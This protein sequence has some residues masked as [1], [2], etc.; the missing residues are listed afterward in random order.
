MGVSPMLRL[1]GSLG[2]VETRSN[3]ERRLTMMKS[4]RIPS[5]L[6]RA[7]AVVVIL[8]LGALC[9]TSYAQSKPPI[10]ADKARMIGYVED[11]FMDNDNGLTARKPLAW[12][13]PT[14]DDK[15]NVTI[16]YKY[17]ASFRDGDR[18]V[19][20]DRFT[21]DKNGKFVEVKNLSKEPPKANAV[22]K[23]IMEV[24]KGEIET[25]FRE[26]KP[27]LAD[28]KA[29]RTSI[30][31]NDDG[32]YSAEYLFIAAIPDSTEGLKG[33][34]LLVTWRFTFDKSGKYVSHKDMGGTM[35]FLNEKPQ[36]DQAAPLVVRMLPANNAGDVDPN[37]P[38]L[39]LRFSQKMGT[40]RS[41]CQFSDDTF[42]KPD[43]EFT[44]E[45][46][47][48]G[49]TVALIAV[50]L[51]PNK[52]YTIG[53][54]TPPFKGFRSEAGELLPAYIYTFKTSDKSLDPSRRQALADEMKNT[55]MDSPTDPLLSVLLGLQRGGVAFSRIIETTPDHRKDVGERLKCPLAV[56]YN[57]FLAEGKGS[58][59]VNLLVPQNP[60]Q[61]EALKKTLA[62]YPH[63]EN[64]S[65]S[66]AENIIQLD[67]TTLLE[68]VYSRQL[69]TE[70][71]EVI[72]KA[73]RPAK[74]RADAP[75][76]V[77]RQLVE[78]WVEKF[79]SQN[80]RDITARQ[81][82]KFSNL[83]TNVDGTISIDYH[84]N[85][86]IWDKDGKIIEQ[87]FTFDRSG[88]YIGH[89]TLKSEPARLLSDD[90]KRRDDNVDDGVLLESMW[91]TLRGAGFAPVS[92]RAVKVPPFH[93]KFECPLALVVDV[94]LQEG[95]AQ[96]NIFVP[97][98][99]NQ[100]DALKKEVMALGT[101]EENVIQ[102]A[103][104]MLLQLI[105]NQ[106]TPE[107]ADTLR[108]SLRRP[109]PADTPRTPAR[110]GTPDA[111]PDE[112]T[113]S[114]IKLSHA[115]AKEMASL[116]LHHIR[117]GR[118]NV[119]VDTRTNS[120]LLTADAAD[121]ERVK[122]LI[123]KLDVPVDEKPAVK[124]TPASTEGKSLADLELAKAESETKI[125]MAE[126]TLE[127]KKRMY[128][129]AV[130][131]HQI[132]GTQDAVVE[133][134]TAE[135]DVTLAGQLLKLEQIVLE[136]I[137]AAI[138]AA[139]RPAATATDKPG[140]TTPMHTAAGGGHMDTM[141]Q[142]M[143]RGADVNAKDGN[144]RTPMHL[145][146][147]NDHRETVKWLKEQG[148]D[149]NAKDNAGQTPM[150][151]A[152]QKGRGDTVARLKELG[153]EVNAKDNDGRTPLHMAAQNGQGAT[154]KRLVDLGADIGV[155]D[156]RGKTALDVATQNNHPET[157]AWLA[158]ASKTDPDTSVK[159]AQ[160]GWKLYMQ[161]KA[162]DAEPL[163]EVATRL[164]PKNAN[165]WQGLGWSQWT[166]EK[167][168]AAKAS[169][170]IC[171][172]L[173]PKN[174][175]ALNGLGQ[176]AQAAGDLD[177]AIAHWKAGVQAAPDATGPL[178]SLA[179]VYE[180]KEDFT[181]AMHYYELWLKADPDDANARAGLA[182]VKE[183]A[184]K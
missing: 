95:D 99:V 144:D 15:G 169:F 122:E 112:P 118:A 168:E 161:G 111:K 26:N 177:A 39:M 158:A 17:D 162:R 130:L 84:Y 103:D 149:V 183:K 101:P 100:M 72:R 125:K 133:M 96:I 61:M 132:L 155:Q 37:T 52:T 120:I 69:P 137:T 165:A 108:K 23:E 148:A 104:L 62:A 8:A 181:A 55:I 110:L 127:Y 184:K 128:E 121:T 154:V 27:D 150:H 166:Q 30:T 151:L 9:V 140:E 63:D 123:R 164:D 153:A 12:S 11:Y 16:T 5:R 59:Q 159:K 71:A 179:R 170:E 13:D 172:K 89:K 141:E 28:Q 2:I 160:E 126:A 73:L 163:F 138:A 116:L 50:R 78:A 139:K 7:S 51:E 182:R 83:T 68:F 53:I 42:P 25:Y 143:E 81:T 180:N 54:N 114:I 113:V 145:A 70:R 157:A 56:L 142:L 107:Q 19:I 10:S 18:W 33:Q 178:A 64:T 105:P 80:F 34:N 48:E 65:P 131:R 74:P 109:M 92:M 167:G 29:S 106:L 124:T 44:G 176:I 35:L 102:S 119:Q 76:D 135:L 14:T 129:R 45:K 91:V 57:V 4:H 115:N 75:K 6:R 93:E 24:I 38:F 3:L 173:D 58:A 41:W 85:A 31:A 117:G 147:Q 97:E 171:L 86:T 77:P 36:A 88:K 87:R 152:A 67:A 49:N 134:E 136:R 175:A 82:L 22:T 146:A 21:F 90:L 32:T 40:G 20:E 66:R 1:P 43:D 156:K 94:R 174:V 60:D 47:I 79:F 98:N 46:L